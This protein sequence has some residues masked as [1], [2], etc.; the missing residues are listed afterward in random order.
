MCIDCTAKNSA[1]KRAKEQSAQ[2]VVCTESN[3]QKRREL[4]DMDPNVQQKAC[5]LA[6]KEPVQQDMA[7]QHTKEQMRSK[8]AREQENR[9]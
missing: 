2:Q 5:W 1:A 4:G 3:S 8:A 6:L 9:Y 7:L